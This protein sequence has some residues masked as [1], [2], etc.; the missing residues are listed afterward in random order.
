MNIISL[1]ARKRLI[2]EEISMVDDASV[3][4]KIEK[5]LK[6]FSPKVKRFTVE[7]LEARIQKSEKDIMSGRVHT[8]DEVRKH[9]GL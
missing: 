7:E 9:L 4:E 2:A 5:V 3:I 1:E 6:S 8:T